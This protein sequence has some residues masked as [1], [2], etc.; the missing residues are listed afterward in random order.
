MSHTM[1]IKI[2]KDTDLFKLAEKFKLASMSWDTGV[3]FTKR[4]KERSEKQYKAAEK[5][6]WDGVFF[7]IPAAKEEESLRLLTRKNG[8]STDYFIELD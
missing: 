2:G 6:F 7:D 4:S 3:F 1:C 5:A 8:I